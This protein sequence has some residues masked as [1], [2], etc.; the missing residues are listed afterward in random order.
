MNKVFTIIDVD[1]VETYSNTNKSITHKIV[2]K[3]LNNKNTLFIE[4]PKNKRVYESASVLKKGDKT[5]ITY[6]TRAVEN[7]G[8]KYN[9]LIAK[10]IQRI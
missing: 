6:T 10:K 2:L 4:C 9:N 1:K 3:V 5:L 8:K 7:K